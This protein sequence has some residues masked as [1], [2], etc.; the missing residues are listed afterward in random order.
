MDAEDR[1]LRR[2]DDRGGGDRREHAALTKNAEKPSLMPC[3]FSNASLYLLRR[4]ITGCMF[5]SLKV[6]RIAAFCCD[7]S[8][9][10]AMRWRMRVI[11]TRC[12]GRLPEGAMGARAS[13]PPVA[14]DDTCCI[15][16]ST[17]S[18]VTRPPRPLPGK[19]PASISCSRASL[20]TEGGTAE[21]AAGGGAV[22]WAAASVSICAINS[23]LVTFSPSPLMILVSTPLLE[24]GSSSTTL[25]VSMSIRFSP[26]LTASPTCLCQVSSVASETDSDNWGTL[27]STM[28][29]VYG[30]RI[31]FDVEIVAEGSLDHRL[32]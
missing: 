8:R 20:R 24:A 28:L 16:F 5:T 32:L 27:T 15:A 25:S 26:S 21:G 12:S 19:L 2:G 11:A 23:L 9:R 17:S 4:S 10:S 6:V 18:L 29:I 3:F 7:C 31:R 14:P 1:A 30:S 13:C 22:I